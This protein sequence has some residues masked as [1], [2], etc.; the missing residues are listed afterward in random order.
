M[1]NITNKIYNNFFKKKHKSKSKIFFDVLVHFSFNTFCC[2]K[3]LCICK[4]DTDSPQQ[5]SNAWSVWMRA[6][7]GGKDR[8]TK[9]KQKKD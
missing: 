5:V 8:I 2:I 1:T 7:W 6:P 3:L 9:N 4:I